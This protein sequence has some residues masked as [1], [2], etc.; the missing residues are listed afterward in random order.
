MP[1]APEDQWDGLCPRQLGCDITDSS[2]HEPAGATRAHDTRAATRGRRVRPD[3]G[4]IPAGRPAARAGMGRDGHPRGMLAHLRALG[5]R[6]TAGTEPWTEPWTEPSGPTRGMPAHPSAGLRQQHGWAPGCPHPAAN[7]IRKESGSIPW[8]STR[9]PLPGRREVAWAGRRARSA[10][11]GLG[12]RRCHDIE[13]QLRDTLKASRLAPG[14]GQSPA[15]P[16]SSRSPQL[17][18]PRARRE[19]AAG[20]PIPGCG[21]FG[22]HLATRAVS[23]ARCPAP[24]AVMLRTAVGA[25]CGVPPNLGYPDTLF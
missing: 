8:G 16:C 22:R 14:R 11:P 13:R 20:T 10:F 2:P 24:R 9:P 1:L 3:R 23:I 17:T 6:R 15:E 4:H 5:Y 7:A 12:G 21:S 18:Q 25:G 19:A